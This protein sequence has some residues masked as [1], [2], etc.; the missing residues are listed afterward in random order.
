MLRTGV[1]FILAYLLLSQVVF[2]KPDLFLLK[3]Y[4]DS[5]EVVGWVMS[6]KLDGIRGFW[7]GEKLVS[8]GGNLIIAQHGLH[9]ATHRSPLTVSF[10]L[11]AMI[12]KI[13]AQLCAVKI[14][15][16]DGKILAIIFLKYPISKVDCSKDCWF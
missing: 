2:A 6:E 9:K 13:L 11:S 12:L 4:D 3:T 14:L 16:I 1:K 8:R 15:A 7:D 10:G 5:K